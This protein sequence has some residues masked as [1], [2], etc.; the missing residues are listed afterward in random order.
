MYVY[1]GKDKKTYINCNFPDTIET[2][3]TLL[4]R[5]HVRIAQKRTHGR[6][7]YVHTSSVYIYIHVIVFRVVCA[8][9]RT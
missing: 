5:T 7:S 8:V 4:P 9:K 2:K 1:V 3:S 6:G